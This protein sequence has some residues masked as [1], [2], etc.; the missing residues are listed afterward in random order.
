MRISYSNLNDYKTCPLKFKYKNI[1]KISEPENKERVFGNL[2]HDAIEFMFNRDPLYPAFD[3][4][5]NYFSEKYDQKKIKH[6]DIGLTDDLKEEG[7]QIIKKFYQKNQP[8]NYNVIDLE[9]RFEVIIG[10][11]LGKE[12]YILTGV[13]DRL[14]K[15]DDDTYEI[16]DYKTGRRL[17]S[18]ANVDQDLQMSIYNL[19]LINRWPHLKNK[20]IKLSLYYLRHGEKLSTSRREDELEETKN[21][22]INLVREIKKR[23][24]NNDFPATPSVLCDWCGYKSICPMWRHLYQKEKTPN[25]SEIK[26]IIKE[27]FEIKEQENKNKL[28]LEGLKSRIHDFMDKEKVDRIFG[29]DGYITRTVKTS[30]VY[31]FEKLRQ[32]LEPLG[33]WGEVLKLNESKITSLIETLPAEKKE[34]INQAIVKIK[35]TK[36]ITASQ[37]TNQMLNNDN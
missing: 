10:D 12:S 30:P 19:G 2:I 22:I 34:E 15:L 37:K 24:K 25:E 11:P 16:I 35:E 18:Q 5:I 9:S 8:W 21:K 27:Y 28:R 26:E 33:R 36:I 13:L 7:I 6:P 29:E 23:E 1:D 31:D 4:I 32:V 3:E 14:D 20:K 17:P